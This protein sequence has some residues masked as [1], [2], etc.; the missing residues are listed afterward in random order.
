MGVL[1]SKGI[2]QIETAMS[3]AHKTGVLPV[4]LLAILENKKSLASC[5][6]V[7]TG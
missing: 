3:M 7:L 1:G 4:T 2:F 5:Y 6:G